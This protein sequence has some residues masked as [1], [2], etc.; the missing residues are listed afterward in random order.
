MAWFIGKHHLVRQ[1]QLAVRA[2]RM[3]GGGS[4]GAVSVII[5]L[6]STVEVSL[7]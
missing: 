6:R 5:N 4:G 7:S 2:V 3:Y 1:R